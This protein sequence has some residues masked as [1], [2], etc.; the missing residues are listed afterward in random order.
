MDILQ[1]YLRFTQITKA[2][3]KIKI[4]LSIVIVI[5]LLFV[6]STL[7]ANNK[8]INIAPIA[9]IYTTPYIGASTYKYVDGN[10]DAE[11]TKA[12]ITTPLP[13][14]HSNTIKLQLKFS[15]NSP[16][17]INR[18]RIYQSKSVN[19]NYAT[20]YSIAYN[21]IKDNNKT[22]I[23]TAATE[24][25]ATPY[26]WFDYTFSPPLI[27][28]TIH[29]TPN[30]LST[31]KGPSYGGPVFSEI[32][33]YTENQHTNSSA[34]TN[35]TPLKTLSTST[36]ESIAIPQNI[37]L[38]TPW[39]EQ[40]QKGIFSSIWYFDDLENR[41]QPS[42]YLSILNDLGVSR[43][44]LYLNFYKN[45]K[46]TISP[47][48]VF[49]K[50]YTHNKNQINTLAIPIKNQYVPYI[51]SPI[52]NTVI[53]RLHKN[54][55]GVI[56][57]EP[58][59]PIKHKSWGFPKVFDPDHY[60]CLLT[61]TALHDIST[62]YYNT[63]MQKSFDGISIGGDEFFFYG[64]KPHSK[65]QS[66][67]CEKAQQSNCDSSFY[68]S[69]YSNYPLKNQL[70]KINI[71][72]HEYTLLAKLFYNLAI[73]AKAKGL[74]TTSLLLTGNY[75]RTSY[76]IAYDIIGHKANLNEM[77][78]DPYWSQQ[79]YLDTSYFSIET[80]K[81]LAALPNRKGHIT[82]QT[83]PN[84]NS[85]PFDDDIMIYGPAI[86]S[87]MNGI[88]GINFYKIDHLF[89]KKIKS[90]T[91]H[92]VKNIF[93]LIQF[94]EKNGFTSYKTPKHIALLYS[95]SSEDQWQTNAHKKQKNHAVL[96]QNA[97]IQS[98]IKKSIPF[99]IFYLDQ[100]STIPDLSEYDLAL[101]PLNY[102]INK[103]ALPKLKMAKKILTFSPANPT[104]N[105][106]TFNADTS[107]KKLNNTKKYEI[108]LNNLNHRTLSNLVYDKIMSI[109][110]NDSPLSTKSAGDIECSLLNKNYDFLIY[111][112]NWNN[113]ETEITLN[114]N[115]PE[116]DYN[117]WKFDT[118]S[119][120]PILFNQNSIVT[121]E[122]LNNFN[123]VLPGQSFRI[124][125][126]DETKISGKHNWIFD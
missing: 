104:Q 109:N 101:I 123:I 59:L 89:E 86:A 14:K 28:N 114:I 48:H 106:E 29:I 82:L 64:H 24:N 62:N 13:I 33:I 45:K 91:Y 115:I 85:K 113:K 111:C 122:Q 65:T 112:I 23:T 52:I 9:D 38:N 46:N 10:V 95:R 120:S 60:P 76:G 125:L 88:S 49:S 18:I 6:S 94:L 99:E 81:I 26:K 68:D 61:S 118:S 72:T 103:K 2:N 5:P 69:F 47:P 67:F 4:M 7:L 44:W 22:K 20:S 66:L 56:A 37:Q 17:S 16:Y 58:F 71:K 110:K 55:I 43:I 92:R 15:F 1:R 41:N 31:N 54:N 107:L 80:K 34:H 53:D 77:S 3:I 116:G 39:R 25:H 8:E 87:I 75:N 74:I 42:K 12:L 102:H 36:N 73:Q 96:F 11:N 32:E 63:L 93:N 30:I 57:N 97:I 121:A 119:L 35:K 27:T 78:I 117:I 21:S 108:N 83:T 19:R 51:N 98:L 50:I 124:Y 126:L 40:F 105:K 100:K 90:P 70:N 84:F 79:N